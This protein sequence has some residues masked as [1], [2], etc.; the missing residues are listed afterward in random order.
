MTPGSTF[1]MEWVPIRAGNWIFH[2]HILDHIVP[3]LERGQAE[4][5]HDLMNVEQHALDAMGGLVLGMTITE[6]GSEEALEAPYQRLRLVALETSDDNG[7]LIRGFALDDDRAGSNDTPMVPGPPLLLTRG[8]TTEITVVNRL[9]EPTTIH[10][11]GLELESVFDGVAGWSRTRSRVAPLIVPGDSFVVRI[12]P[13]RAGT[14]IYHTHMDETDQLVQ[15]MFGPFLVLEPGDEYEPEHDRV[16][17]IGGAVEGDY[18]TT[19]NGRREPPMMSF[20]AG[21]SYRLRFVHITRG[22]AAD[23]TLTKNGSPVQ[24]R[25]IAKDGADLPEALR[26]EGNAEFTSNTG[27][28]FDFLWTPTDRGDV[29]LA[30]TH[31]G[32]SEIRTDVVRQ[33]LRVR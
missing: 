7:R 33:T 14:F 4:R 23:I 10:W 16:F 3:S 13:P 17:V 9:S 30:L 18:P 2:C 22:A 29:T 11:H 20:R 21:E 32:F 19:L 31:E 8:E 28:T 6:N 26:L 15:G 12:D 24:W 27:Q 5:E 1:R 25:A